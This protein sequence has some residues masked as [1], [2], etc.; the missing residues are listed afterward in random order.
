[1]EPAIFIS[2]RLLSPPAPPQGGFAAPAWAPVACGN[3]GGDRQSK[4]VAKNGLSVHTFGDFARFWPPSVQ[5][6][7]ISWTDAAVRVPGQEVEVQRV[8]VPETAKRGTSNSSISPINIIKG[9]R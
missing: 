3:L 1:M 8:E 6:S 7:G 4:K 5:K 2:W 9:K